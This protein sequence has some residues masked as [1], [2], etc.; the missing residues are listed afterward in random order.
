MP[1]ARRRK[2]KPA[3]GKLRL[4]IEASD[5]GYVALDGA[6]KRIGEITRR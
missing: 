2:R 5:G 4:R 6:S 3:G 1:P